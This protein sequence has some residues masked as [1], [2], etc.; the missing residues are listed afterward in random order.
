MT[1]SAPT[2]WTAAST[3]TLPASGRPKRMLSVTVPENRNLLD[4]TAASVS[5]PSWTSPGGRWEG[6]LKDGGRCGCALFDRL[7]K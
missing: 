7:P 1:A 6:S 2:A 3:S 5:R 4:G